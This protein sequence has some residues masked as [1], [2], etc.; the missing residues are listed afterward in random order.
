MSQKTEIESCLK[1]EKRMSTSI[2]QYYEDD[3]DRLDGLFKN[4]QSL[5]GTDFPRA[6]ESFVQFK[7]GLQRHIVWEEEILFPLFERKTGMPPNMGPTAVMRMEHKEIG[8]HLEAIHQKV[9]NGDP[10]S[11]ESEKGLLKALGLHNQK[12]EQI[13]YPAIDQHLTNAEREQVFTQMREIPEE[14]YQTCCQSV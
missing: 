14:R 3:H 2:T 9:K 8:Q 11:D 7:F 1:E 10:N 6:K 4:F 5:K 12:E 13:L